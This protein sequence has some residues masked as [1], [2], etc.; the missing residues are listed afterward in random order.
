[1]N[2]VKKTIQRYRDK[3]ENLCSPGWTDSADAY[4]RTAE[5]LEKALRNASGMIF[6]LTEVEDLLEELE[7]EAF[8]L[9]T[10]RAEK[11]KGKGI[12]MW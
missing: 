1:M 5:F 8:W 2:L 12:E 9:C 10:A 3:S 4:I 7:D 6:D 11:H